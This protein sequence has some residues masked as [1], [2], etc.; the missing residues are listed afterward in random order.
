MRRWPR[1]M[2]LAVL[3]ATAFTPALAEEVRLAARET[4]TLDF[5][6]AIAVFAVDPSTV[7]V[8]SQAGQVVL[9]GRRAGHTLVTVV[10]PAAVQT[11]NVTV[12]PPAP[13]L[14]ALE[15]ARRADASSWDL[16]Y[17][18]ATRRLSSG[19]AASFGHGETTARLQLQ[20]VHE[21]PPGG[22]RRTTALPLA[23]LEI[24]S[25][26]RSVVLLDKR[27]Q[28]SPLT[29][30]GAVLRGVH[31][32]QGA[33]D[34]HAGIASATPYE[35]FLV[36][37]EGDRAFGASWRTRR[38]GLGLVP[39]VYWLPDSDTRVPLIASLGIESGAEA[40]ALRVRGELGWSGQPGAAIDLDYH[41]PQRQAWLKA[42][43]R[44]AGFAALRAARPAG[45]YVD[46]AWSEHLAADTTAALSLSANRLDLAGLQPEAASAR[47]DLRNQLTEHWNVNAAVGGGAYR[48]SRS[49]LLR[50]T[51]MSV[52]SGYDL[53]GLGVSALYRYQQTSAASRGGHG[54]RVS[55]R[56]S[57]AGWK[58]NF[59]LDAQQ[60]APTLDLVLQD[61]SDIAR[62]LTELGLSASNPEELLRQLRD[63]AA[64]LS[65]RGISIGQL[66]LDPLRLQS[67][68]DVSWRG[69]GPRAPEIGLRLLADDSQGIASGRR[70]LVATL[71]A[72]WR[73]S[74][75]TALT[76]S[77]TRWAM[78]GGVDAAAQSSVQ[79]SLRTSFDGLG[80]PGE[81]SRAISGQ[82][83]RD[84][85]AAGQAAGVQPPLAGVEVVLDRSRRSRTD[86]DGRF[87][88][89]RPGSGAHRV[90]AV[91][92]PE[93]GAYF[94]LPSVQTL[95][96]GS[97]A[98]FALTFS[99]A[100]LTG[101]V[102]SD[103]GVPLAGVTVRIEGTT[104]AA[105]TTDSSGA[106]RFAGPPGEVSVSVLAESL[107]AGY[108]VGKMAALH[109]R[110]SAAAPAV[111]EFTVRAQRVIEGVVDGT[112]GR[113]VTVRTLDNPRP[114]V[115]DARGRFILRGL[116]AG[117]VTLRVR[118]ERGE[119]RRVVDMPAEPGS[120]RGI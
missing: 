62:A 89:E 45:S 40:D 67:G 77:Y 43:Y 20:A 30:D 65:A 50:R 3:A 12:D 87:S 93:P 73:L 4:R 80:M 38:G 18:T 46:A 85:A 11:L 49:Q 94:T 7:E 114:V 29:V 16:H 66:R 120:V 37:G 31:L 58:A 103:A 53:A 57:G 112:Q 6:G 14:L 119:T 84:D 117:P 19:L 8:S 82:V 10:L 26:G 98:R 104:Q 108:D 101:T 113:R 44:P 72:G 39:S 48:D 55:L 52:G 90:E 24:K 51:A 111:A 107:P 2:L 64:L 69:S 106:Y 118:N 9:L 54:A 36:P 47:L 21:N 41:Q 61:R 35:D 28:S 56:G 99:G 116:P 42:A 5:A 109:A 78:R 74:A 33:L 76:A 1:S 68:L 95:Q 102:R 100:R 59:F 115:S 83:L 79:M 105:T 75:D 88:F 34:V 97:E 23:S 27:M 71:Y 60:Q 15:S 70:N 92:P 96:P 91:L 13:Q 17:D 32:E 25:P 22:E 81:G 110:L 63:N 86:R